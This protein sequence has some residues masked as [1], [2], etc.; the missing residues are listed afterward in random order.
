MKAGACTFFFLYS[1][2]KIKYILYN[3]FYFLLYG[4]FSFFCSST[5][6][7]ASSRA[8]CATWPSSSPWFLHAPLWWNITTC[9]LAYMHTCVCVYVYV[10]FTCMIHIRWYL[11]KYP[12]YYTYIIYIYMWYMYV[13][14]Y[15]CDIWHI[16]YIEKK[17]MLCGVLICARSK[18][19]S[20]WNLKG[21]WVNS[22]V[23]APLVFQEWC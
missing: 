23:L 19:I 3:L 11:S 5:F 14:I 16:M 15:I 22:E 9:M 1:F 6:H 7:S 18:Q 17:N 2:S 20:M 8:P 21:Q 10:L 12:I 13:Y 4:S